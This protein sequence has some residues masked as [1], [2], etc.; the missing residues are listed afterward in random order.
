MFELSNG[1]AGTSLVRMADE[2]LFRSCDEAGTQPAPALTDN[3]C[4]CY[5]RDPEDDDALASSEATY[6]DTPGSLLWG[7][8]A[9][10]VPDSTA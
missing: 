4:A 1:T 7:F 3:K 10:I 5:H 9:D 2:A 6:A 8:Y